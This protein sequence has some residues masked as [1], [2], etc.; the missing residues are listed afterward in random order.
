LVIALV[1]VGWALLKPDSQP[2]PNLVGAGATT[3]S[4]ADPTTSTPP[5]TAA[6]TPTPTVTA[7]KPKPKPTP[8]QKPPVAALPPAPPVQAAPPPPI[9]PSASASDVPSCIKYVGT[10]IP[11]TE[12]DADL[13]AA[14]AIKFWDRVAWPPSGVSATDL[15]AA[16]PITVDITLMRAVAFTE[17]SWVSNVISCDNGVGLM[18][19]MQDTA[20]WMNGKFSTGYDINTPAQNAKL[21]AEY[22]EWLTFYFGYFYFGSFDL[23]TSA[24]IGPGNAPITLRDA[25]IAAYNVGPSNIENGNKLSI[26]NQWYVDR[27]VGYMGSAPWTKLS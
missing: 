1:T 8:T 5:T 17:S 12:V 2:D 22:L 20:T 3:S 15:P 21:G 4:A 27:V 19:V 23:K 16:P 6:A 13:K 25:V 18:Q 9:V 7:T 11:Y 24:N 10:Q 14:A 26:P